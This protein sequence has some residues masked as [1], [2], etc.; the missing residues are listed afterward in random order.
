MLNKLACRRVHKQ[1]QRTSEAVESDALCDIVIVLVSDDDL[2][3]GPSSKWLHTNT[4]IQHTHTTLH[5]RRLWT[6]CTTSTMDDLTT[7]LQLVVQQIHNQR[8]KICHTA[9]SWYVEMLGSDTAMWQI[10]CTTSCRIVVSLS[11][12]G[13]VQHVHSRCPCSGVW[14]LIRHRQTHYCSVHSSVSVLT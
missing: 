6:C 2:A 8:T 9:T 4:H 3:L 5:G 14:H 1:S 7:I 11:I 10:C 13:V 12:G